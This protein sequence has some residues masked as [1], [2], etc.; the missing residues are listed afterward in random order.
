MWFE[1]P[2]STDIRHVVARERD[3]SGWF[4]QLLRQRRVKGGWHTTH[5][6]PV[7]SLR[8]WE[9]LSSRVVLTFNSDAKGES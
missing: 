9:R 1:L 8:E 4:C 2:T 3:S 6:F 5:S 7:R